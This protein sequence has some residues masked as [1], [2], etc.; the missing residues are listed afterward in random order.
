MMDSLLQVKSGLESNLDQ[1]G[2]SFSNLS[3]D[4]NWLSEQLATATNIIAEKGSVIQAVKSQQVQNEKVLRV[5]VQRL[6]TVKDRQQIYLV[7][8]D[9][10][11]VPIVSRNPVQVT[12]NTD[13]GPVAI[14]AQATQM[15]NVM[16][17]QS[18]ALA[19]QLED[20]LKKGTYIVAVYSTKG[21]LGM[22]GFRLV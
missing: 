22:A 4:N 12:L 6:Q 1:L 11:G 7:I 10:Q 17:N 14:T 3:A 2:K 20:R 16:E 19:Y 5:Q 18:I 13:K 9:D 15:Q 21:L 8:T